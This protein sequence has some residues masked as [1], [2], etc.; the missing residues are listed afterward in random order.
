MKWN[1]NLAYAIGLIT[2]DGSLSKDGRH[3]DF[4][5]KDIEQIKNLKKIL[6]LKNKIGTKYSGRKDGKIYFRIQFGDVKFYRFLNSI[7]LN[8]NKTKNLKIVLVPEKYFIDFLRG[9]LDGDGFTYSYWDKR[10]KSSFMLYTGVVSASKKNLEWMKKKIYK[11]YG[12]EGRI[13]YAGKSTFQLVYAKHNSIILL[14]KIYYSNNLICLKR[15]LLKIRKSL[16]II[17]KSA[18]MAKLVNAQS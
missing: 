13:R 8:P 16:C 12:I 5:S 2:A 10:W 17:N 9:V 11:L 4:T 7:G 3:I 15:K 6:N 1:P 18:G 14:G